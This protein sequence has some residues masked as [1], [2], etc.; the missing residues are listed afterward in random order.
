L[1]TARTVARTECSASGTLA[2]G[3]V[4]VQH[5]ADDT[6]DTGGS[7]IK[8]AAPA[9]S[10]IL[11]RHFA[12][13]THPRRSSLPYLSCKMTLSAHHWTRC[14]VIRYSRPAR[15]GGS[16]KQ[17]ADA[18]GPRRPLKA[19]TSKKSPVKCLMSNSRQLHFAYGV[20]TFSA[21]WC[22][23]A[24]GSSETQNLPWRGPK[25]HR[26]HLGCDRLESCQSTR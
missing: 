24:E 17:I 21:E 6:W 20:S 4:I 8:G 16:R 22:G 11:A 19:Q 18:H 10:R 14:V 15:P 26:R 3:R 2:R 25:S 1:Q 13:Q 7:D 5:I 12:T 23:G 9:K